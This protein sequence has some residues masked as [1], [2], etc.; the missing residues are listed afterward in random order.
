MTE[1]QFLATVIETAHLFGWMVAHFR[2][3]QTARTVRTKDGRTKSVW[4]TPVQGD[5]VG[6]P[7][8]VLVRSARMLCWELKSE[9]G[10]L[11]PEQQEW[12]DCLGQIPGAEVAVYRP[13][14]WEKIEAALR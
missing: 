14:D 3:A 2:P 6:W 12:L 7:D 8:L 1:A 4:A 10:R 5:G 9:K 11:R 13:S